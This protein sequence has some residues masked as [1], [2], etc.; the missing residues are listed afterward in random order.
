MQ[1]TFAIILLERLLV[2]SKIFVLLFVNGR[3]VG[4]RLLE[5]PHVKRGAKY[6]APPFRRGLQ[7]A[8][9]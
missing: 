4:R 7:E 6:L 9:L 5:I 2:I 8:K 1:S 3:Y